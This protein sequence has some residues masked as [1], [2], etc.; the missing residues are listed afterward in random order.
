MVKF[1]EKVVLTLIVVTLLLPAPLT[2]WVHLANPSQRFDWIA[3]RTLAGVTVKKDPPPI[4][5]TSWLNGD[6]QKTLNSLAGENFAG[7]EL[8]IRTYNEILYRAFDKS[9]MSSEVIISGKHESLFALDYLADYGHYIKPAPGEDAEALVVMMKY[10]S[11]RLKQ[12]GSC[13]VFLITPSKA[14]LYPEDIPDRY[15]TNLKHGERRPTDYEILVSLL[16][17]YGVPFVDG[18]QIT[19]EHKGTLPESVFPKTGIHWTRAVAFFTVVDLLKTIE[20]ESGR[21]MP[22]LSESV[23]SINQV[24]DGADGDLF[25]LM[26]L[27]EKPH[28]RYLHPKIQ[29][30]E[31]WPRRKGIVTFVGGSFTGQILDDI[32]VAQVFERMNHYAYFKNYR[33]RYPGGG[34]SFVSENSIPW[35]EDF[36][37]TTAVVLEANEEVVGW[38]RHIRAFLVAELAAIEQKMPQERSVEGFSRP[39]A[40][41]FGAGENGTALA[42]KGFYDPEPDST[43]ISSQDAEVELPSPEKNT[44]LQLI[45]E[46]TAFLGDGVSERI[47][48]IE[49]NGIPIGTLE[50]GNVDPQVYSLTI[51]AAANRASYLKLHFSFSPAPSPAPGGSRLVEISLARLALVPIKLPVS[52]ETGENHVTVLSRK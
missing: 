34:L 40:W 5:L 11:E 42:K 41:G 38:S 39:L 17:E 19:L 28:E 46:G 25:E 51:K 32:D 49:A 43:W 1:S 26:N 47:L 48:K 50:L 44:D 24:P 30:P 22:R 35:E 23:E 18:R 13:F 52:Q 37:N 7:R 21:K 20:Q 15:L 12:L 16:K 31:G 29:I 6:F 36:W 45:L 4:A 9:Y 33:L 8:L 14:T 10:L 2:L 27:I 3:N